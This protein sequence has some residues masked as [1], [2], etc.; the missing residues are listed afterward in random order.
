MGKAKKILVALLSA[1]FLCSAAVFAAGCAWTSA[2]AESGP[3]YT[4]A[5]PAADDGTARADGAVIPE[6]VTI[7][8]TLEESEF[9]YS[10]ESSLFPYVEGTIKLSDGTTANLRTAN[11]PYTIEVV[12][13]NMIPAPGSGIQPGDTYDIQVVVR[14]TEYPDVTCE[15]ISLRI[16]ASTIL[17]ISA[18]F[19][20]GAASQQG[21]QA[22][23]QVPKE[24]LIVT[25][26]YMDEGMVYTRTLTA[27]EYTIRYANTTAEEEGY[28]Q[29]GIDDSVTIVYEEG[30]QEKE[31]SPLAVNVIEAPI[32]VPRFVQE[33]G[34]E[35]NLNT[36]TFIFDET[37]KTFTFGNT[38][39]PFKSNQMSFEF[40]ASDGGTF[41]ET[42]EGDEAG[43]SVTFKATDAGTYSVTF[44]VKEGYRFSQI[45][46]PVYGT[47]IYKD[48]AS[49]N[50]EE[51]IGVT[52]TWTIDQ[53]EFTGIEFDFT[54][55]GWTYIGSHE[56]DKSNAEKAP[57]NIAATYEMEDGTEQTVTIGT[58]LASSITVVYEKQNASGGWEKVL[59][60]P[61]TEN[62]VPNAAGNYCVK[63]VVAATNNFEAAES[64]PINFTIA[65]ATNTVSYTGAQWAYGEQP[66]TLDE[67]VAGL[68]S[69]FDAD[70]GEIDTSE[71]AVS[72][73]Y[74]DWDTAFTITGNSLD[75]NAGT[76]YLHVYYPGNENI[77]AF[78]SA[79]SPAALEG[80]NNIT[81]SRGTIH[82][83]GTFSLTGWTFGADANQ[84]NTYYA[85]TDS[86]FAVYVAGADWD[87][88]VD[89]GSDYSLL[90]GVG[91]YQYA[92]SGG[93]YAALTGFLA[94]NDSAYGT[95][96]SVLN[97]GNYS[98]RFAVPA[99][100][101]N[102]AAANSEEAS[103]TVSRREV[104]RPTL[105][106][107][108][109]GY[110][111]TGSEQEV[112]VNGFD[113]AIMSGSAAAA[114]A[115][116]TVSFNDRDALTAA[117]AGTYT[118]TV[119]MTSGNYTWRG[120]NTAPSAAPPDVELTWTIGKAQNVI[121]AEETYAGWTYGNRPT[122]T[123][124]LDASL[125]FTQDGQTIAYTY[126]AASDSGRE[127]PVT[128]SA[129][130][131]AGDYVLVL[132]VADSDN[133]VGAEIER[134]FTVAVGSGAISAELND[135]ETW[136]YRDDLSEHGLSVS[137]TVSGDAGLT[138]G[139]DDC[140]V[141][142]ERSVGGKWESVEFSNMA[143]AGNYRVTVSL[144]DS[145]NFTAQPAVIEF[146]IQKYVVAIPEFE[147]TH[148]YDNSVWTP[149]VPKSGLRGASWSISVQT[150]DSSNYGVYWLTLQLHDADNYA[151][152][153]NFE[154]YES[155][156][157][158][159]TDHL[160]GEDE[161]IVWLYYAITKTT[162]EAT[163][164]VTDYTYGDT[165]AAPTLT[166]QLSGSDLAQVNAAER[167][168]SYQLSGSGDSWT[169][170]AEGLT[171]PAGEYR[172]RVAVAETENYSYRVFYGDFTV[173][174]KELSEPNWSNLTGTY[175]T[176]E[177]A[178]AEFTGIL[179][180]DD[181]GL[182]Y[183]YTGTANDGTDYS[184][185]TAPTKAGTYTVTVTIGNA[186]YCISGEWGDA[187][188]TSAA[189]VYT[190]AKASITLK[191]NDER[192]TY[193]D[194]APGYTYTMTEGTLYYDDALASILANVTLTYE[195][196]YAAG[197]DA[198]NYTVSF[199]N[200]FDLANYTVTPV[201]G[202]LTVDP[203]AL[204]V[205]IQNPTDLVYN[206]STKEATYTTNWATAGKKG[207][208][209]VLELGYEQ[210]VNN[211]YSTCG[212]PT[213]VGTYRAVVTM[214]D[215][216]GNY[217]FTMTHGENYA[218]AAAAITVEELS[219]D[220]IWYT[221]ASYALEEYLGISTVNGQEY[222]VTFTVN[223]NVVTALT[224]AGSYT[225]GY[226]VTAPNHAEVTG[227]FT[228]EIQANTLVWDT[229]YDRDN[230]T[231]GQSATSETMPAAKFEHGTAAS[232][233]IGGAVIEYFTNEACT[234]RYTG[235]FSSTTPAGTYYVKVT[236]A[237]DGDNFAALSAVYS[238]TVNYAQLTIRADNKIV[239]Y[240]DDA[241]P[242][243]ATIS[244]YKNDDEAVLD[245]LAGL[246][247]TLT[248]E[249]TST[250]DY[251]TD[252]YAIVAADNG[253]ND[254]IVSRDGKYYIDGKYEVVF[255]D[256]ILS[257]NK[258]TLQVTIVTMEDDERTYNGSSIAFKFN[259]Y[260]ATGRPLN[261]ADVVTVEYVLMNGNTPTGSSSTSAPVNAGT[262]RV[263]ITST[264]SNY[265]TNAWNAEFTIRPREV[266]IVW[267]ETD[268]D[269]YYNGT[270]QSGG[271]AASY[272]LWKN[273]S[274]STETAALQVSLTA[275]G[276][277]FR[278]ANDGYVFTASFSGGSYSDTY[279]Y[280]SAD[281]N[282]RMAETNGHRTQG[283][284]IA[285]RPITVTVT[286][287]T[288]EYGDGYAIPDSA[289]SVTT[290]VSD[291]YGAVIG[292]DT[293]YRLQ[294]QTQNGAAVTG[295]PNADTYYIRLAF[296]DPN[297]EVTLVSSTG[298]STVTYTVTQRQLQ[299]S[300][301]GG[302]AVTYGDA[303]DEAVLRALIDFN[304]VNGE[305]EAFLAADS[306][307]RAAVIAAL[308]FDH[309]GYT[310]QTDAGSEIT[311]R[312]SGMGSTAS[313]NYSFVYQDAAADLTV[314]RRPITV[315]IDSK[316][317]LTYGTTEVYYASIALSSEVKS[318]SIVNNDTPY[319]LG[320]Y[321]A[322]GTQ[323]TEN[324]RSLAV[325]DYY[326]VGNGTDDNYLIVFVGEMDYDG[327]TENAG[328]FE[329][330]VNEITVTVNPSDSIYYTGST[331]ELLVD[332]TTLTAFASEEL[333]FEASIGTGETLSY[334]FS[335]SGQGSALRDVGSY[336]V[337]YTVSADNYE[338]ETG[339]F[340]VIIRKNAVLWTD[341]DTDDWGWTYD[342]ADAA[343]PVTEDN[344][345]D[346]FVPQFEHDS[347]A[348][349]AIPTPIFA[350]FTDASCSDPFSGT[351]GSDT[352]A[353][354]YYVRITV[355]GTD[356]YDGYEAVYSFTVEQKQVT[357]NWSHESLS[358]EQA[359][360]ADA[361]NYL[362]GYDPA[363]MDVAPGG[364]YTADDLQ[365]D[366]NR[367]YVDCEAEIDTY[368][369][370][371]RLLDPDNY[372]WVG[373]TES[374]TRTIRFTVSSTLIKVEVTIGDWTYGDASVDGPAATVS[375]MEDFDTSVIT[376]AYAQGAAGLTEEE[377]RGLGFAS[378]AD[379]SML[380]AGSYW[381]RAYVPGAE[382]GSYGMAF[383]YAHFTVSPYALTAPTAGDPA[384]FE[385]TGTTITYA[386]N[387]F[388]ATVTLPNGQT[389][390]AMVL[391]GNTGVNAGDYTAVVRLA[392]GNFVWAGG[393]SA[394]LA[395]DWEIT[396]QR[397]SI[398]TIGDASESSGAVYQS[399]YLPGEGQS[400]ATQYARLFGFDAELMSFAASAGASYSNGQVAANYV[401][402]YTITVAFKQ[403][404]GGNYCWA[405]GSA[406][407]IRLTW[408]IT[409]ATY[410]LEAAG[411]GYQ[412]YVYEY[413]YNGQLQYPTLGN[414]PTGI[415]VTGYAGGA[416]DVSEGVQTVTATLELN[417]P[418]ATNFVFANGTTT[419]ELTAEV[420]IAAITV[421]D[422]VWSSADGFT[423]TGSDQSALV[424]AYFIKADGSVGDLTV[425]VQNGRQFVNAGSYTFAVTGF[426]GAD[427]NYVLGGELATS[428]YTI[429]PVQVTVALEDP[430]SQVYTGR[431][432]ELDID[433]INDYGFCGFVVIVNGNAISAH[434]LPQ[435]LDRDEWA[436][437][438]PIIVN[439]TSAWDVGSY[440]VTIADDQLTNYEI[441]YVEDSSIAVT[442]AEIVGI[443]I[444]VPNADGMVYG[445]LTEADA[446]YIDG[447]GDVDVVLGDGTRTTVPFSAIA[448][449][450]TLYYSGYA[451]G[452][453]STDVNAGT[454]W[455]FPQ[456][457]ANAS[458]NY[459]FNNTVASSA[460]AVEFT[461]QKQE[462]NAE[463]FSV[464]DVY[465]T[466]A[467]QSLPR[468]NITFAPAGAWQEE[469]AEFFA[470]P[471][472]VIL[473]TGSYVDVDS[474]AATLTLSEA[475][476]R[477]YCFERGSYA[478]ELTW[479]ILPLAEGDVIVT[480][481]QVSVTSWG[482]NTA[483]SVSLS[484]E[485]RAEL[486]DGTGLNVASFRYVWQLWD[487][488]AWVTVAVDDGF[489]WNAGE[490]QVRGVIDDANFPAS[491]SEWV[492][493][494][495][496]QGT[497][498]ADLLG[499]ADDSFVYDGTEKNLTLTV[500]N[501]PDADGVLTAAQ[502]S[503]ADGIGLTYTIGAGR[504]DVGSQ[505]VTVT[506]V[507][508]SPNY[509]FMVGGEAVSE[510]TLTATL[511]VDALHVSVIWSGEEF[512]Y[513][514]SDHA[515]DVS[516]YF[517]NANNE[518]IDLTVA[519]QG[520][521]DFIDAGVYTFA[522][523][524]ADGI[525]LK[526]YELI[527]EMEDFEIVPAEVTVVWPQDSFVY[528]G[529]DQ[530]GSVSA[531]FVGIDGANVALTLREFTFRN[532]NEGGYT[533]EVLGAQDDS[534]NMNNYRLTGT[535]HV[536]SIAPLAVTVTADDKSVVYGESAELTWH[537][538]EAVFE[539][540]AE[541]NRVVVS[542]SRESGS[543]IGSYTITVT[544]SGA[545]DNYIVTTE[546]G[547]YTI[548]QM[549]TNLRIELPE[550]RVY[551]GRPVEAWL[552]GIGGAVPSDVFL[553]YTGTANDG[554]S[555]ASANAPTKAG[556]YT[557]EARTDNAS[558]DLVCSSVRLVIERARA[559][560]D[561]SG[562]QTHYLYTGSL[563]TVN[564]G[565]V[566]NHGET[567]L[568]YSN[569]TFMTVAEGN[570]L[571]V[572][573]YAEQ[574]ANYEAAEAY[575]TITVEQSGFSF[576]VTIQ[577]WV[578]G[579]EANDYVLSAG[580]NPGGGRVTALYTG[581]TNAG[582]AYES[583]AAPTQA[584]EYTL[585]V[586]IAATG[587]YLGGSASD[588]FTVHRA[589]ANFTVEI[590]GW[591][592]GEQPNGYALDPALF[593]EY[594]EN[595]YYTDGSLYFMQPPT[596][597][598]EYTIVVEV[599]QSPNYEA[600]S[601]QADFAV[602]LAR[603][604]LSVS[605]EGWTYGEAP[606]EPTV[607]AA[608]DSEVTLR[609]TGTANDGTAWDSSE[610]PSKA[611]DYTLTATI[612]AGGNYAGETV[613]CDFAV[614]RALV[615]APSLGAEGEREAS[616]VYDGE[617][618][619]VVVL[620]Y[621]G[622]RMVPQAAGVRFELD[623]EKWILVADEEGT[624]TVTFTLTDA[625]NY[626][627]AA[628]DVEDFSDGVVLTWTVTE[629]VDS[630]LWLIILLIVLIVLLLI[631][632]ILLICAEKRARRSGKD[633][634]GAG[635]GGEQGAESDR[636]EDPNPQ[637]SALY[638]LVPFGMLVVPTSH[639]AAVAVLAAAAAALL[640]V[641]IWLF[642]RWR[643]AVRAARNL[644]AGEAEMLQEG[645][646]YATSGDAEVTFEPLPEEFSSQCAPADAGE[647]PA[648]DTAEAAEEAEPA[649]EAEAEEA[650]AAPAEDSEEAVEAEPA[651]AGEVPAEDTA[652][653]AEEVGRTDGHKE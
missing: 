75:W 67:I 548:A 634:G 607:S 527:G 523:T 392:G 317:G 449:F 474:Y 630:L 9:I 428:D 483:A 575:V 193:G 138:F 299:I 145:S 14:F 229:E 400:L 48:P 277:E 468:E 186:N 537:A 354:T 172:W 238:F 135:T 216:T 372:D 437:V 441:V 422:I 389:V 580:A 624:Y 234:D 570:G 146:T 478:V 569:N 230:W 210:W 298:G 111:Y 245:L 363:I 167:T 649:Q 585:T 447:N 423:Y 489:V 459:T 47:R 445:R 54:A 572:R 246:Q 625:D 487:G 455:V 500:G 450:V 283:Y 350:Y 288:A 141:V 30:T 103:F 82:F 410:D 207:T 412:D 28:L 499:F 593:E 296:T 439:H 259:V 586:T 644:A 60:T 155:E 106:L 608:S 574:T 77:E 341:P 276:S 99:D 4:A 130:T 360:Q 592:Y 2:M 378:V 581:T 573:I 597:V 196:N 591:M 95:D 279:G 39:Y 431:E 647:V 25:V 326:I 551:D 23:E 594:I 87:G 223:S 51:I 522:V 300:F 605:I 331:Y 623:G 7:K 170:Y 498:A 137:G 185:A 62:K 184:S 443:E 265:T 42:P 74:N 358:L 366:G 384:S 466:G 638:A 475:V 472:S 616:A 539:E 309:G 79:S 262:Y 493:F 101:N 270:V 261:A 189:Q 352:D 518:R 325:G 348:A 342:D 652:E 195:D 465:Y 543:S 65:K 102:Y 457:A 432:P 264:N 650:Q 579:E 418:Y 90:D 89:G 211:S 164:N 212:T 494:T 511:T 63:I 533:F 377:I 68:S 180:G 168:I 253:S 369:I 31:S 174:P 15:P 116:D 427:Q 303:L 71:I 239:T 501:V 595:V 492:S 158:I 142:Y 22:L 282:Y 405:D 191:V 403:I 461:V 20:D 304:R 169:E 345:A 425:A 159:Y 201:D 484:V 339:S 344:V 601:A 136:F 284:T 108:A 347:A 183:L 128:I 337:S 175:G 506:I 458:C 114:D 273:G 252:G 254:V 606:N 113:A 367:W 233:I 244:G 379:L 470:D 121:N 380:P 257:M 209:P 532:V 653:A 269:F 456:I 490:Y 140:T 173:N 205:T 600:G 310:Q 566:L 124:T 226:T 542:L 610:A 528:N 8:S 88:V 249:Y 526:N 442:P 17:A 556:T 190:I 421:A 293:A 58:S 256:G 416:T 227:S 3:G 327:G 394:A 413:V 289:V 187:V 553:Y 126:Y 117:D 255:V 611:G 547:T 41:T 206:G 319:T 267:T 115:G 237:G 355:A 531:Y 564:S 454:V 318:G 286:P 467:A 274:I 568:V 530:F 464:E 152:G 134:A 243:T 504:T 46:F 81:V 433:R 627:W 446:A 218:I 292:G 222:Q 179:S 357:V 215:T 36:S 590:E 333:N 166:I 398:P 391:S 235:G 328:L 598:G 371:I 576:S 629:K 408:E 301:T 129:T 513:D 426:A 473:N 37:E 538:S 21:I 110:T 151:W 463:Q 545:L 324:W 603:A 98:V 18:R 217:T 512:V 555:W 497:Y 583:S 194:N 202:T 73:T 517:Y 55:T 268:T 567:S 275:G 61:Y 510:F 80:T 582:E 619:S 361:R 444:T 393:S 133:T 104:S 66:V 471:S 476:Y 97:A 540:D 505:E 620:G 565:A 200:R 43:T 460:F 203:F 204:T 323:I 440:T 34:T 336:T 359:G 316:Q 622:A 420:Q 208:A 525:D 639:I 272:A 13:G 407:S 488:E 615:R 241:P 496:E 599:A 596:A 631:A 156:E 626:A 157:Q 419:T 192:I 213:E 295:T 544:V 199:T 396:P 278:N 397:L 395:F 640:I 429:V 560:I 171:L 546:N 646:V 381:V 578:Y 12:E 636:T 143:D 434:E 587:N 281:G 411:F 491:A 307:V 287:Q 414:P 154:R 329:V 92:R 294:V 321:R 182:E 469:F 486:Q 6:S 314:N 452:L 448:D 149:D 515:G 5:A 365:Q 306:A 477:N 612:V 147:R 633:A 322:D 280:L 240:G 120:E 406:G 613:S 44:R 385:Y 383:G 320:V 335:V 161:S 589:E 642:V 557:V 52:Y 50:E 332:E 609:Y 231:Y 242:Y 112:S 534:F 311:V 109:D 375:G 343:A 509:V 302:A 479:R 29:F 263:N 26:T 266:E 132:S 554:T 370:I 305:G 125:A 453:F 536:L 24:D 362:T 57:S 588:T 409:P 45:G 602:S 32:N 225:V 100:G 220:D 641:D 356:N 521:E 645:P 76:Y 495:V 508:S 70:L 96:S 651:D 404:A 628:E 94:A 27:D 181:L 86:G 524:G 260:D 482:M 552:V 221:G 247:F 72:L 415:R 388:A 315:Q 83:V 334:A 516:A 424:H 224:D 502:L 507:A 436:E 165:V 346:L 53:A 514:G 93:S 150:E 16:K 250:S 373:D 382:D 290:T 219:T 248:S 376:Y 35:V 33:D 144:T 19:V 374:E 178:S 643:R 614:A 258:Q 84:D 618:V 122:G 308:N 119:A 91:S 59:E 562:V 176:S 648:E 127:T 535:T 563:Q 430:T 485:S 198:T 451:D 550:D 402:T 604:E 632:L 349:G 10:A 520:G 353:G 251:L 621:D 214:T 635:N 401:G 1:V 291:D 559:V 541:A 148:V 529:E 69:A 105:Q 577:D 64:D 236:V 228:L 56:T 435:A 571:R 85:P 338:D 123:D 503:A 617:E 637:D 417:G 297:Y 368:F 390:A 387:G 131:P 312:I 519:V 107:D 340:T 399:T 386:L 462:I 561:V 11:I 271:I 558:Y 177:A 162:Y 153:S 139:K 313:G 438:A 160:D 232:G 38:S 481:P 351:F 163:V 118:L 584:G 330:V 480:M 49:P 285:K 78:G 188:M 364:S 549:T 40:S 197:D